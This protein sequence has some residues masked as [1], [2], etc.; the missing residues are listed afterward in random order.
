[1]STRA[2]I[3]A[4]LILGLRLGTSFAQPYSWETKRELTS[5]PNGNTARST[6]CSPYGQHILTNPDANP[7]HY[8]FG[9]DGI[10]ISSHT[11]N[12]VTS[13]Y[14]SICGF[15]GLIYAVFET[16]NDL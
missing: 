12:G 14:S 11:F 10:V 9:N 2:A 15:D 4:A 8:L 6:F 16:S 3:L 7:V 5:I 1:M 13:T